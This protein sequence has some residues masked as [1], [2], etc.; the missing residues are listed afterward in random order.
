MV[1]MSFFRERILLLALCCVFVFASCGGG[2]GSGDSGNG[3]SADK[4]SFLNVTDAK[5][6][7]IKPGS[8]SA[9]VSNINRIMKASG[10]SQSKLMK[11]T[12]SG[13]VAE[14]QM[15]DSSHKTLDVSDDATM[16]PISIDV[17]NDDCFVV[18]FGPTSMDINHAYLCKKSDGSVY[19]L[20]YVPG[21][22]WGDF[23]NSKRFKVDNVN[24]FYYIAY[25]DA[26]K[27]IIVKINLSNMTSTIV[28][29]SVDDCSECFEVDNAGIIAYSG[30]LASDM[31]TSVKRIRTTSG[32]LSNCPGVFCRLADGNIYCSIE[33]KLKKITVAAD[34]TV[35]YDLYGDDVGGWYMTGYKLDLAGYTYVITNNSIVE[36]YNPLSTPRTVSL[37]GLTIS[38]VTDC[39][40]TDN[41]Y[42]IAG[43]DSSAN[44][45]LARVEPGTDDYIKLISNGY[46]IYSMCVDETDG[47]TFNALRMSDGKNIIGKI[48]ISGGSITILDEESDVKVTSLVRIR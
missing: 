17:I 11:I 2:G 38:A 22:Y 23:K 47:V 21:Y 34:D 24:N 13:I 25:D 8:S 28:S 44:N 31:M 36:L 26:H 6:M 18:C 10:N 37:A 4:L 7:Y 20:T 46:D 35:S 48:P 42:F 45:F 43:R 27:R 29:P 12:E 5:N 39:V 3:D 15:L 32:M 1:P 41:Y 19:K 30:D 16:T 33:N 40:S 9:G 14:I